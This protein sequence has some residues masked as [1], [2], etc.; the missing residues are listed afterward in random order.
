M[1]VEQRLA[2]LESDNRRLKAIAG[3]AVFALLWL[4]FVQLGGTPPALLAQEGKKPPDKKDPPAEP[5]G[6]PGRGEW[7]ADRDQVSKNLEFRDA[8]GVVRMRIGVDGQGDPYIHM[9]G[10]DEKKLAAFEANRISFFLTSA[11]GKTSFESTFRANIAEFSEKSGAYAQLYPILRP[12][13][14]S[15]YLE[16]KDVKGNTATLTTEKLAV[17]K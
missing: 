9:R 5:K 10:S 15:W 7:K 2:R 1:N 3:V 17:K 14:H 8:K 6:S 12:G 16:L 11:D 4:L 13:V